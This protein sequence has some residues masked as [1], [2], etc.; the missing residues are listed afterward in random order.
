VGSVPNQLGDP[1]VFR[2]IV[3]R[4]DHSV[5]TLYVPEGVATMAPEYFTQ[6]IRQL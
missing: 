1:Q 6:L 2:V 5:V 3:A 4:S